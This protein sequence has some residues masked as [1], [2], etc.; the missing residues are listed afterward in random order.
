MKKFIFFLSLLIC[1]TANAQS[2][3]LTDFSSGYNWLIAFEHAGNDQMFAIQKTGQIYICDGDGNRSAAPFLDISSKVD[4]SQFNEK[5]LLGFAL[6]PEYP[7]VDNGRFFVF[8]NSEADGAVVISQFLRSVDNSD[9][10]DPDSEVVLLRV[11]HPRGNHTGGCLK[12]GPDGYLYFGIGDGGGSNDPDANGQKV[13]NLLGK[14]MRI[15]VDGRPPYQIP[16]DNPFI[17]DSNAEKEIWAYGLRNPW[18]FSFDRMTGDL[19][20]SDVGQNRWEEINFQPADSEGGENYGWSCKEGESIFNAG[21]CT[22]GLETVDPVYQYGHNN[23]NC[24]GSTSGGVVYRGMEFGDLWGKHISVDYCSGRFYAVERDGDDFNGKIIADL[25]NG[26]FTCLEENHLGE[27]FVS[28]FFGNEILKIESENISPTAVIINGTEP[29]II[30][31]GDFI[32]LLAYSVDGSRMQFQWKKDGQN[33]IGATGTTINVTES[34]SYSIEVTNPQ[35]GGVGTSVPIE[36]T[37]VTVI[38]TNMSLQVAAGDVIIGV[39]IT[40][41]TTITM[42]FQSSG[43]CDS[44]VTYNIQVV[45]TDVDD[46]FLSENDFT[47]APNPTQG[48]VQIEFNLNQPIKISL[49]LNDLHGKQLAQPILNSNLNEGYHRLEVD[50]SHLPK[51]IYFMT[52]T[53]DFGVVTRRILKL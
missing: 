14:V 36:I 49:S 39:P 5:G 31:E 41:D 11:P 24:S 22:P 33:I 45:S 12:F 20:I 32:Q 26:E 30:C 19:W 34:G 27:I 15:D 52:A 18:R 44:V 40:Q 47:I 10:A 53:T 29:Q 38:E 46:I 6:H 9:L 25:T 4:H 42:L 23:S 35:N 8:Y 50:I 1:L 28:Q 17:D 16:D 51:G 37:V 13:T 2:I 43:G 21:R 3:K 48:N 7:N